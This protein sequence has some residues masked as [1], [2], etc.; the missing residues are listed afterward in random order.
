MDKKLK[1][2]IKRAMPRKTILNKE[3]LFKALTEGIW[4]K[5]EGYDDELTCYHV[6]SFSHDELLICYGGINWDSGEVDYDP[7]RIKQKDKG[8]TWFLENQLKEE[9]K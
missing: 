7:H 8:K 5:L 1:E 2:T 3:D 4:T 9:V 6:L